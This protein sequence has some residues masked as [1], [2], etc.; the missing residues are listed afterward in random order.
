MERLGDGVR[1]RLAR[2]MG[3]P[4]RHLDLM[5][6]GLQKYDV[7]R[8]L[9][10]GLLQHAHGRYVDGS[11]DQHLARAACA[12]AAHPK[13]VISHFTAAD[14][15]GLRVWTDRDRRPA[16]NPI[17]LSC[18][19][20]RRRNLKR[21]DVVLHRAGLTAPDLQLHQGLWLTSDAR[22]TVDIARELPLREAAVTVDHALSRSVSLAELEAVLERQH[23][24]PGI[25][26][27]RE[28]VALGDPRSESAL[29]SYARLVFADGGLP[30]PVLQAEFWDGHR[31]LSLRV[32]F[33]WPEFRTVGEADGLEK[34]EAA[35]PSERR[36][37]LRRSFERDQQLSDRGLEVVHFGWEDAVLR[38]G[39][40]VHRFRAAFDRGSRRTDPAPT[41]RTAA[42]HPT[43]PAA[44]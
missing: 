34:F 6:L 23:R 40:L 22:T 7:E 29:E 9:R 11:L 30:A 28:A 1:R 35:T 43:R 17:W 15:T 36:R 27:A 12:Q 24:W 13:S 5:E 31:W 16:A 20:G 2:R 37:L 44:A 18:E 26:K 33:W 39:D 41:W 10:N 25:R 21:T 38:P 3:R 32:D 4:L 14:L 42:P 8:L 19:P